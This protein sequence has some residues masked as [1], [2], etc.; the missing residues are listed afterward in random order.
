MTVD[1]TN[2]PTNTNEIVVPLH[3]EQA[4]VA[5]R[6]IV[7][8]RVQVSTVTREHEQLV[9]E[10]LAREEVEIERTP[11]GKRV[12]AVPGIREEG[13]TT[14]IPVV[15]EVLVVE[16][17][18]VLKEEIRVRR[19]RRNESHRERVMLRRQEAFVTRSPVEQPPTTASAVNEAVKTNKTT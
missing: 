3:E 18:L 7:T 4:S 14:V 19:V 9:D 11:I 5:K 17:H 2:T 12:A 10:V 6:R 15:E 8:G 13:D 1:R 16:R